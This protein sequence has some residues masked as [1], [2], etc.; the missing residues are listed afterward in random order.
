VTNDGQ[1]TSTGLELQV[2]RQLAQG[3]SLQVNATYLNQFVNYTA[4]TPF[5]PDIEPALLH[6]GV[7]YHPPYFTPFSGFA[8]FEYDRAGW[9][10][11]PNFWYI[12]GYPV[13]VVNEVATFPYGFIP[14]TNLYN[15]SGTQY[16]YYVDPQ[17]PGTPQHPNIVGSLGGGCSNID[18]PLTHPIM[19]TG[20]TIARTFKRGEA[21]IVI[22][23]IFNNYANFP[24]VNPGYVNNGFGAYGP[25]SGTNPVPGVNN[26]PGGPFIAYPSGPGRQFSFYLRLGI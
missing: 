19:Y 12:R 25:G 18:Q 1:A 14:N 23:N 16:C 15:T 22:Q 2:S 11:M 5:N 26:Y 13:G 24:Y 10:I 9:R 20:I 8:T 3:L 21:G 17:N 7:F 6:S 4:P